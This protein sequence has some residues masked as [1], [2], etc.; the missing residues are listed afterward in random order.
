MK[1]HNAALE[2]P[3]SASS[4][5]YSLCI[6]FFYTIYFPFF[7]MFL[8][9][10]GNVREQRAA[11]A[12][13]PEKHWTLTRGYRVDLLFFF[14]LSWPAIRSNARAIR[15]RDGRCGEGTGARGNGQHFVTGRVT[16]ARAVCQVFFPSAIYEACRLIYFHHIPRSARPVHRRRRWLMIRAPRPG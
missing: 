8:R 15:K 16:G 1:R 13:L 12:S 6:F 14:S 7:F 9:R 5:F 2:A 3:N 4:F 10:V 11:G